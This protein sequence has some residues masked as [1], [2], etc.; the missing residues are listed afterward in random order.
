MELEKFLSLPTEK[1]FEIARDK[2][3]PQLGIF[4][5]DG[6]RRLMLIKSNA[7]TG[8]DEYYSQLAEE[9]LS[10]GLKSFQIFFEHGL[11]YLFTPL[12]SHDVLNR[13]VAY[14]KQT[15]RKTLEG[16]FSRDDWLNFYKY[17]NVRVKVY[18]NPESLKNPAYDGISNLI[19]QTE[20]I[21]KENS[22][23]TLFIGIG[24]EPWV[25]WDAVLA[26]TN[27]Y[28]TYGNFPSD[29]QDLIK[30]MYGEYLPP[31]NFVI[32]SGKPGGLGALPALIS[33]KNTQIFYLPS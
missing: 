2:D 22:T 28:K 23:H 19:N 12:F 16:L 27:Y 9:Q 17:H 24:G 29:K 26:T 13:D 14:Q 3:A 33:G 21:T 10:Y 31:A 18:G 15:A 25:G 4:V 6:N 8:T 30:Y 7:E 11:R 20:K 32:F 1:I 5:P